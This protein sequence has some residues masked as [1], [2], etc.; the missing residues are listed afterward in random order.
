[1]NQQITYKNDF[2]EVEIDGTSNEFDINQLCREI[3][4]VSIH[5]KNCTKITN[6]ELLSKFSKLK[7]ITVEN[8]TGFPFH[9][10]AVYGNIVNYIGDFSD[11]LIDDL[12]LITNRYNL[13]IYGKI[14]HPLNLYLGNKKA[15]P[16]TIRLIFNQ[17]HSLSFLEKI[18]FT[19]GIELYNIDYEILNDNLPDFFNRYS[20]V[21]LD[22][23]KYNKI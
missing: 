8:C 12:S 15:K 11:N 3:N 20:S 1:M 2:S 14:K 4:L 10:L 22:E 16:H 9:E 19:Y 21:V 5:L 13:E 23:R 6:I 7:Y 18:H 17:L